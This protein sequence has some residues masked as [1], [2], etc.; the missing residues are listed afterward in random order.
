MRNVPKC[1][2]CK[3]FFLGRKVSRIM[4]EEVFLNC[5]SLVAWRYRVRHSDT[6]SIQSVASAQFM[7][8]SIFPPYIYIYI[9]I[10]IFGCREVFPLF[11]F[12]L[13]EWP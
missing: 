2:F 12:V 13:Y 11:F 1:V 8:A 6:M 9:Y 7:G 4:L 3:N 5:G 10:Y